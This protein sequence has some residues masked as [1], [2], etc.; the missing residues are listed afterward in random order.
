MDLASG[1]VV[2]DDS[3]S[4]QASVAGAVLNATYAECAECSCHSI[5]RYTRHLINPCPCPAC[6]DQR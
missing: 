6:P 4:A 3:Y 2:S 1:I 5:A